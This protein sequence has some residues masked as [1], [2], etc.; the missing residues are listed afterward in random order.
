VKPLLVGEL[1]PKGTD[2]SMALYPTPEHGSGA[3]LARILGLSNGEYLQRF[4][5]ANLCAGTWAQG[6]ARE[7][8]HMLSPEPLPHM[9]RPIVAL[10]RRVL[11]AFEYK[12]PGR[13]H[14][15]QFDRWGYFYVLPNPSYRNSVWNR[16]GA[17]GR[18]R[19]LLSDLL[20]SETGH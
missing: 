11:I 10:G 13:P 6:K 18:A 17:Q 16:P 2:P 20:T 3:R 15:D 9:V 12:K 19:E 4:D 14:W 5:R 8:A 1:T 7:A